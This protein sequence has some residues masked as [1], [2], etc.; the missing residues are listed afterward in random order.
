[1]TEKYAVL[2]GITLCYEIHGEGY[3]VILI[4]GY[5][6]RKEDWFPQIPALSS[7]FKV[8]TFDN[9][10]SGKSDHPN[11]LINIEIFVED[12]KNL[13]DFLKIEK[14]H[15]IGRSLGGIIAQKFAISYPKRVAKL[16]LVNTTYSGQMGEAIVK[17]MVNSTKQKKEEP[18][19]SYLD[20]ARFLF[21]VSFRKQLEADLNRKFYN[22][23]SAND[24][25]K[26]S[27]ENQI[28]IQDLKN[29][30]YV[31]RNLNLFKELSTIKNPTLLIAASHDRVL[32]HSQMIEMSTK[33][34]NNSLK[35]I[36]KAGHGSFFSRAP[37]I[38]NLILEFLLEN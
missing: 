5:A 8:I 31:F 7:K 36:E 13:M 22:L 14:T 20:S 28:T 35:I 4:H 10:N 6:G 25:I 24:L 3:P 30:G 29:Q 19:K 2:R 33:I 32:P 17:A 11:K 38:N 23:F 1:M 18:V 15:I 26:N 12:L 21:H 9:R 16:I 34:P 37:E 27:L